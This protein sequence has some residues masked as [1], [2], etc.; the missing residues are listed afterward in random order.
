MNR[1]AKNRSARAARLARQQ[2]ARANRP[3]RQEQDQLTHPLLAMELPFS[4]YLAWIRPETVTLEEG[5]SEEARALYERV[6]RLGPLYGRRIPVAALYLDSYIQQGQLP[7]AVPDQPGHAALVPLAELVAT[8][9]DAGM[10]AAYRAAHPDLSDDE[11]GLAADEEEAGASVHLLHHH[12][13]LVLDDD[14]VI[15]L[16]DLV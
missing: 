4:G 15:L 16:S 6:Q 11:L 13:A 14:N 3:L 2:R 8:T 5:A 12:G 1:R 7:V 9:A 10:V